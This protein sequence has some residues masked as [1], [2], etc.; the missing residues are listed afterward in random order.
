MVLPKMIELIGTTLSNVVFEEL[1]FS[2]LQE[3]NPI[4]LESFLL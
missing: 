1:F 3:K 2:T 4:V